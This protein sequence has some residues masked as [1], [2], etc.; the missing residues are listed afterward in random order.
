[1]DL[2]RADVVALARAWPRTI[3]SEAEPLPLPGWHHHELRGSVGFGRT[4]SKQRREVLTMSRAPSGQLAH[5]R[6][7]NVNAE[8]WST[9]PQPKAAN[10]NLPAHL[11]RGH[12]AGGSGREC[13]APNWQKVFSQGDEHIGWHCPCGATETLDGLCGKPGCGLLRHAGTCKA[14]AEYIAERTEA[15]REHITK[16]Q[17]LVV[18][19]DDLAVRTTKRIERATVALERLRAKGADVETAIAK[20]EKALS[21]AKS[22][23]SRASLRAE[24]ARAKIARITKQIAALGAVETKA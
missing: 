2:P 12:K 15:L 18:K 7:A 6:G 3:I 14:R 5:V 16:L 22:T 24:S 8:L 1:M 20:K 10:P 23:L 9:P 11:L 4:W 19:Y 21:R 17:A 13:E